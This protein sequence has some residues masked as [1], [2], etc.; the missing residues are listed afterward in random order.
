MYT[1]LQGDVTYHNSHDIPTTVH[2][3]AGMK[4]SP[5]LAEYHRT[6]LKPP[7]CVEFDDMMPG[8][9]DHYY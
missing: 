6:L 4:T 8:D 1:Y 7:V 3:G 2:Q 5:L 9:Y